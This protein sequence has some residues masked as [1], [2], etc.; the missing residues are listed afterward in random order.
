MSGQYSSIGVSVKVKEQFDLALMEYA[1]KKKIAKLSPSE[2]I[3][4]LIG[5]T[6]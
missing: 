6:K 2:Y 1:L 4:T 3:L 5:K